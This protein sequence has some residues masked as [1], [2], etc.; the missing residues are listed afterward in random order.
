MKN[1]P[2]ALFPDGT[3]ILSRGT[4]PLSSLSLKSAKR[5]VRR[6]LFWEQARRD[7]KHPLSTGSIFSYLAVLVGYFVHVLL[8]DENYISTKVYEYWAYLLYTGPIAACLWA[9]FV[10]ISSICRISKLEKELGAWV[11]NRFVFTR[12]QQVLTIEWRPSYVVC[13]F[14]APNI[15]PGALID[16]RIEI[17]GYSD[18][19]NSFVSGEYY[20]S[21]VLNVLNSVRFENRGKA[22][23][24][25]DGSLDLVA[26]LA[27]ESLPVILRVSILG[28]EWEP[29]VLF[30]YTDLRRI[31]PRRAGDPSIDP[32]RFLARID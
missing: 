21:P 32:C 7:L 20:L 12:P 28:W 30:D 15:C 24:K 14:L 17:E 8:G 10:T 26:L 13:K 22:R 25:N 16:Y 23:L 5:F 9:L 31:K 1:Q 3:Q 2:R 19:I 6:R 27:A 4:L 29:S 11:E 18:R